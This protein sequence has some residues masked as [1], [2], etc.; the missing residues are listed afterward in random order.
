MQLIL[1]GQSHQCSAGRFKR[2]SVARLC[3][4]SGM[5]RNRFLAYFLSAT[6]EYFNAL[7]ISTVLPFFGQLRKLLWLFFLFWRHRVRVYLK[8]AP[9]SEVIAE[10]Q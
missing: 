7:L 4:L 8:S 6:T 3:W 9:S 10:R 2:L 5:A 1:S